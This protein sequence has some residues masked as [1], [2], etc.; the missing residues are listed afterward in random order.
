MK[1][2][3]FITLLMLLT[4]G[5]SLKGQDGKYNVVTTAVPI[6]IVSPDARAGAMGDVGAATLADANSIFWNPAN[7]SGKYLL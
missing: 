1:K 5:Y 4:I 3:G 2:I 6:L 7:F